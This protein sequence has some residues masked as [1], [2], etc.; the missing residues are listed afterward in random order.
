MSIG[1]KEYVIDHVRTERH[2]ANYDDSCVYK[3]LVCYEGGGNI[4]R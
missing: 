1:D 4:V 3:T 2:V